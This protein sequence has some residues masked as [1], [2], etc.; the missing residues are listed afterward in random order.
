MNFRVLVGTNDLKSGGAYVEVDDFIA[1][2]QYKRSRFSYDIGL[3]RV[4]GEIQFN[5]KVQP[6][7]FT[8]NEVCGGVF[9][10]AFGWGRL[11]VSYHD[12]DQVI[13]LPNQFNHYY[14]FEG[15]LPDKLQTIQLRSLTNKVCEKALP[16]HDSHLCTF[17]KFG[18][19][20]C[21]VS[22]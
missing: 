8:R 20:I 5:D 7:K 14:Q 12:N 16:V 3:I 22:N 10:R 21:A 2:P 4:Q 11:S 9:L 6:I 13:A 17:S 15:E 1:H 19:G 18:E